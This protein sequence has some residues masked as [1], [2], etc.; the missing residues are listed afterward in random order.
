MIRVVPEV[1]VH[2]GPGLLSKILGSPDSFE[3][4]STTD[5]PN[6]GRA[7]SPCFVFLTK[8]KQT[9]TL[10]EDLQLSSLSLG[11]PPRVNLCN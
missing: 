10:L 2:L 11:I 6:N 3:S 4:Y 7:W 5:P 1:V 8:Q 9:T